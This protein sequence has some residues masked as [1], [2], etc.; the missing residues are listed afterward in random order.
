ML[1][2]VKILLVNYQLRVVLFMVM[3][4]IKMKL[5]KI[6]LI[7]IFIKEIVMKNILKVDTFIIIIVKK[8]L[9]FLV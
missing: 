3:K 4:N 8:M 5:K 7:L 1:I 6:F 9:I 2:L